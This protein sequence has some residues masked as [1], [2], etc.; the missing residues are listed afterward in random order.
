M[1]NYGYLLVNN[2]EPVL[3]KALA[4]YLATKSPTGACQ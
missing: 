4:F 2:N 3:N 1:T